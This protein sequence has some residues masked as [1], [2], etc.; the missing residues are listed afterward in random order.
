MTCSGSSNFFLTRF[1]S[2]GVACVCQPKISG[3]SIANESAVETVNSVYGLLQVPRFRYSSVTESLQNIE[4]KIY[5]TFNV[6]FSATEINILF[7]RFWYE[8]SPLILG[9]ESEVD[10]TRQSPAQ[11]V[12]FSDLDKHNFILII[13]LNRC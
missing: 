3:A 5:S 7:I 10:D 4:P 12:A 1:Y 6:Y 11:L 2:S 13:N 8:E 9:D